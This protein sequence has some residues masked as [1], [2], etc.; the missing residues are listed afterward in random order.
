MDCIID[1][2]SE[3]N[4]ADQLRS[5][6][7]ADLRLHVRVYKIRFFHNAAQCIVCAF[8]FTVLVSTHNVDFFHDTASKLVCAFRYT[9][10]PRHFDGS[11]D[12]RDAIAGLKW[13]LKLV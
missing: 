7:A 11:D 3:N 4:G 8:R 2:C 12:F 13:Y 5:H 1:L 9:I 6:C 10:E